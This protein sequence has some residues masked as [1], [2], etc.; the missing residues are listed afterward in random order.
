MFKIN[1][2]C[3]KIH[4][5][6]LALFLFLFANFSAHADCDI[7]DAVICIDTSN[8]NPTAAVKLQSGFMESSKT[9]GADV[10]VFGNTDSASGA[11]SA[12][13]NNSNGNDNPGADNGSKNNNNANAD[14]SDQNNADS[15][16]NSSNASNSA[17]QKA[18]SASSN[19]NGFNNSTNGFNSSNDLS[20]KPSSATVGQKLNSPTEAA[21]AE[22]AQALA[23]ADAASGFGSSPNRSKNDDYGSSPSSSGFGSNN[24]SS[25]AAMIASAATTVASNKK[26]TSTDEFSGASI[27]GG[28][29]LGGGLDK[30][31]R[32]SRLA[33]GENEPNKILAS[34]G[35][36][37]L[38]SSMGFKGRFPSSMGRPD[39]S[40]DSL[41][42]SATRA[43]QI[44][45]KNYIRFENV[46]I[47]EDYNLKHP[48]FEN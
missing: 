19:S 46:A 29:A 38:G 33:G 1:D 34:K 16:S 48:E 8:P 26:S 43:Y 6:I 27:H 14:N 11:D 5:K 10:S 3:F 25:K 32:H 36:S 15:N 45:Q 30:H 47:P 44:W 37:S 31:S 13:S 7:V 20:P 28:S 18:N 39:F 4:F 2:F 40:K 21:R 42:E 41:F 12:P 22:R 9:F 24:G 35:E 23:Q 17:A